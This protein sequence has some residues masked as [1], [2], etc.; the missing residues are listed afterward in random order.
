MGSPS[1]VFSDKGPEFTNKEFKQLL[2]D[3][4]ISQVFTVRYAYFAERFV[5]TLKL[6][7]SKKTEETGKPW[8]DL[9]EGFLRSYNTTEHG[10]QHNGAWKNRGDT[11]TG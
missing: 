7:M 6:Y 1:Y 3:N 8:K 10:L 2:A 5:K 11:C 4:G 9:L